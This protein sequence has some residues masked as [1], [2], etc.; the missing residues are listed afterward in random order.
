MLVIEDVHWADD[1]TLALLRHLVA[2]GSE[3]AARDRARLVIVLTTHPPEPGTVVENFVGRL[4]RTHR[5]RV[6]DM[7]ALN[8][9]EVRELATD[10]LE[11]RPSTTAV[12]LLLEATGGNPLVLRSALG[13]L[14][15]RGGSVTIS[16]SS[17]LLGPTDLDHE[18]WRR[19]E[20]VSGACMEMLVYAAI[21]GGGASLEWLGAVSDLDGATLDD[22]IDEAS[23]HHVLVADDERYWFDHPQLRQLVYYSTTGTERAACHLQVADRL[24]PLGTDVVVVAHHLT[25]RHTRRTDA[26]ACRVR[27]SGRSL[28]HR[29]R[30]ARRSDLRLGRARSCLPARPDRERSGRPRVARGARRIPRARSRRRRSPT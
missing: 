7:R 11:K 24:A 19:V 25:R 6:I 18:L 29:R 27:R 15:E 20:R 22:L 9:T 17:D 13:R 14:R 28:G 21:L 1:A 26:P 5:T 4:R 2:V 3:E 12:D 30:V 10:W 16:G 8:A 23:E